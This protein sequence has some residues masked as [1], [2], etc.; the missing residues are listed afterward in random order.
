MNK[1]INL[2]RF[3]AS[4][5][6]KLV[7]ATMDVQQTSVIEQLRFKNF[8]IAVIDPITYPTSWIIANQLGGYIYLLEVF[9][10]PEMLV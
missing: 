3:F 1:K 8:T 2:F 9:L 10:F 5:G 6:L 7:Y 4:D